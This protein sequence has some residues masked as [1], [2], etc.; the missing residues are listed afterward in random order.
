MILR[1]SLFDLTPYFFSGSSSDPKI[2]KA[3]FKE[4]YV[5]ENYVPS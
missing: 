3:G 1:R 2:V 5:R 4:E